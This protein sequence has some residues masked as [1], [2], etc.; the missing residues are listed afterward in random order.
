MASG[1]SEE[2]ITLLLERWG[3]GEDG[4]ADA[5]FPVLY[6]ELR[7]IAAAFARRERTGH[8]LQATAIVHEAYVRLVEQRGMAWRSR[9]HF[10]GL[11]ARVMRRVL[12]DYAR[13]RARVKRGGKAEKVTLAEAA[14][15]AGGDDPDL[16]A[17][18]DALRGLAAVDPRLVTIVELRFF[19]GLTIDETARHLGISPMTV[20]RDWR[21]AK[22]WLYEELQPHEP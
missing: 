20:S 21:R 10:L 7:R 5:L 13:E 4:A 9:G 6:D 19:A 1:A 22:A 11:V 12:V 2:D 16:V 17:L 14:A 15:L 3:S 8:T 18:D